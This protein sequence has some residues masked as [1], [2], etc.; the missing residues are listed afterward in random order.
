MGLLGLYVLLFSWAAG[1]KRSHVCLHWRA[2]LLPP[3][4]QQ[5]LHLWGIVG[6]AGDRSSTEHR[7]AEQLQGG[8]ECRGHQ[9]PYFPANSAVGPWRQRLASL[10]PVVVFL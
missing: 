7:R 8:A 9:H 10:E 6:A 2:S 5:R 4:G 3:G 1:G